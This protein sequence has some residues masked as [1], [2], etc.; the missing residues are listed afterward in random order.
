MVPFDAVC[1]RCGS[2][3]H[4]CANCALHDPLAAKG[5]RHEEGEPGT[6]PD[7]KNFCEHFVFRESLVIAPSKGKVD[8]RKAEE[9]WNALF[10]KE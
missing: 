4:V 2:H 10:R 3:L 6:T 9:M 5:C 1:D 7:A 8:R